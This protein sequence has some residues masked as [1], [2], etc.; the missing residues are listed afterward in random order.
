M[1]S[2][3]N[4]SESQWEVEMVNLLRVVLL[5][6]DILISPLILARCF[7]RVYSCFKWTNTIP[8]LL[9]SSVPPRTQGVSLISYLNTSN[10]T[11]NMRSEKSLASA[12]FLPSQKRHSWPGY[13]RSGEK[14]ETTHSMIP[15]PASYLFYSRLI[16]ETKKEEKT[17]ALC[18]RRGQSTREER[19]RSRWMLERFRRACWF[20]GDFRQRCC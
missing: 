16:I 6:N 14:D 19:I 10:G 9:R 15:P 17:I 4:I 13:Q 5:S 8:C 2:R 11:S 1:K 3:V 12:S 20:F 18:I 7:R